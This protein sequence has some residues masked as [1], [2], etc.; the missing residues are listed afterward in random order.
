MF[1]KVRNCNLIDFALVDGRFHFPRRPTSIVMNFGMDEISYHESFSYHECSYHQLPFNSLAPTT[2]S[3]F[4]KSE[5]PRGPTKHFPQNGNFNS[6]GYLTDSSSSAARS[7]QGFLFSPR[8]RSS[9]SRRGYLFAVR[10]L[11]T[12]NG[13]DLLLPRKTPW[14]KNKAILFLCTLK[15]VFT[16]TRLQNSSQY[17]RILMGSVEFTLNT[18]ARISVFLGG[19]ASTHSGWLQGSDSG[20]HGV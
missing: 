8:Q 3:F 12:E 6:P 18:V 4:S 1:Q 11:L 16:E 15:K 17:M 13:M 20:A 10:Q 14:N 5:R 7:L 9:T 19:R 2:F